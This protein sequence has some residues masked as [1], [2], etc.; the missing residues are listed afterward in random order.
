VIPTSLYVTRGGGIETWE[1]NTA[2]NRSN[3]SNL[4]AIRKDANPR[5]IPSRRSSSTPMRRKPELF[6]LGPFAEHLRR[7]TFRRT[8]F[9][10]FHGTLG[11]NPGCERSPWFGDNVTG[12]DG[13][14][15]HADMICYLRKWIADIQTTM[16]IRGRC[17]RPPRKTQRR[18]TD[19]TRLGGPVH[20]PSLAR[21]DDYGDEEILKD[22]YSFMRECE[23]FMPP[24]STKTISGGV[25]DTATGGTS[26]PQ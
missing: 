17:G 13:A 14:Y 11:D 3:T 8:F 6:R 25:L 26:T 12:L 15:Y 7:D 20:P 9:S 23:I 22:H 5:W 16:G 24:N 2:T 18:R 10:C 21:V 4:S 1:T 19:A